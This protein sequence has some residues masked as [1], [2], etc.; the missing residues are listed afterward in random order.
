M[1]NIIRGID[2]AINEILW[3]EY[4]WNERHNHND[5]IIIPTGDGY[6]IGFHP[7]F[8]GKEILTITA[9]IFK[10][11]IENKNFQIRMG[12]AKGR[13]IRYWDINDIANLF[14]PGINTANRVIS[15]ALENQILVHADFAKDILKKEK[16]EELIEVPYPLQIK[17][18]EEIRVFNYFKK[19]VFGNPIMPKRMQLFIDI[20][21][22]M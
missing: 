15:V 12:L 18:G 1:E 6:G 14:G 5:L 16:I 8:D 2:Y 3:Q 19:D 7:K 4:N 10:K 17:T 20:L 13:N 21:N 11:L 22:K 9:N